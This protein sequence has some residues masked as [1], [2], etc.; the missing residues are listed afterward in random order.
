MK[1]AGLSITGLVK[2]FDANLVVDGAALEVGQGEIVAL[3]GPSGCGKTTTLRL[4]A[5]FE[6]A[7]AG[8][9]A[10]AGEDLRRQPPFQRQIG[11]V[12]QDYALFPHMT[13][14]DNISYGLRRRG[15]ARQACAQRVSELLE[16][17]RLTG[18]GSRM[19]A[20]LSGGQ[21]QRVALARALAISPKLLLLDEPLSNLD[22][23][24]REELRGE[25]R[26][27]LV[28]L[29]ITTLVV[30]HDQQEAI[31]LADRI[32]VMNRGRIEQIG[33]PRSV[34]EEPATRFVA[35][36]IGRS[37]WFDGT[38]HVAENRFQAE[39]QSFVV[40]APA[41]AAVRYGLSIRPEH[42]HLGPR[43]DDDNRLP[44]T[45]EAI[46]FSGAELVIHCRLASGRRIPVP[47]RSDA[48]NLPAVGA[49]VVIGIKADR[50]RV[51]AET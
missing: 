21:Q 23:K 45:V 11:L 25:L 18:L 38:F 43:A 15:V 17:V 6:K 32:A 29:G 27:L 42:L 28:R 16:L 51:V 8:V 20:A 36:F 37:L 31:G 40:A 14:A 49:A 50:C 33:T 1:P 26:D 19:P 10:I 7:D 35:D 9:I 30:T 46:E 24:L 48:P 22:A 39:G 47:V 12:F 13:V 3:L 2:R 41:V 4:I 44:A 34:Y 5:G